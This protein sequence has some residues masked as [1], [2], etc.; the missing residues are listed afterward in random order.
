MI[1]SPFQMTPVCVGAARLLE[2]RYGGTGW[3][4]LAE[5]GA[6]GLR[7]KQ[8]SRDRTIAVE[9]ERVDTVDEVRL[10]SIRQLLDCE[11]SP[12]HRLVSAYE[13]AHRALQ[14]DLGRSSLSVLRQVVARSCRK[15]SEESDAPLSAIMTV[16]AAAVRTEARWILAFEVR[17]RAPTKVEVER[18]AF[19]GTAATVRC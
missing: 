12:A 16:R 6:S 10:L 4:G 11:T 3:G 18:A 7:E 8:A 13:V 9:D 19:V 5:C 2:I 1:L 17:R 15:K 14:E